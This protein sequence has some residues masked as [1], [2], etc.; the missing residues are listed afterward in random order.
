MAHCRW[1]AYPNPR[2]GG[3]DGARLRAYG[4][5]AYEH[6]VPGSGPTT[7]YGATDDLAG[8]SS[9]DRCRRCASFPRASWLKRKECQRGV[10]ATRC[11]HPHYRRA[12]INRIEVVRLRGDVLGDL[13]PRGPYRHPACLRNRGIPPSIVLRTGPD[14][15]AGGAQTLVGVLAQRPQPAL[16]EPPLIGG[17]ESRGAHVQHERAIGR[18][19]EALAKLLGRRG[20]L[21]GEP[22]IPRVGAGG[23]HALRGNAVQLDRFAALVFVPHVH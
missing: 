11:T 13:P 22:V 18:E 17:D 21:P 14:G 6:I 2:N 9:K 23:H 10:S 12:V 8:L 5:D 1:N 16:H 4:T 20:G 7:A 19:P 3:T 15:D